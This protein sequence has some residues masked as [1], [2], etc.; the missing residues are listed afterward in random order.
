MGIETY[1]PF[2]VYGIEFVRGLSDRKTAFSA[3]LQ[4]GIYLGT[5]FFPILLRK[6][7]RTPKRAA[8]G[9]VAALAM[10][11]T[12]RGGTEE[13]RKARQHLEWLVNSATIQ[14][15]YIGWGFPYQWKNE[16]ALLEPGTPIGHTTMTCGNALLLY[17]EATREDWVIDPL[18]RTCAFFERGLN[19]TEHSAETASVSYTPADHSQVI[20]VSADV[21]SLLLRAGSRFAKS[22]FAELGAKLVQWVIERQNDDGSWYYYA[23]ESIGK[24]SMI[25]NRHTGMVLSALSESLP[26]SKMESRESSVRALEKGLEYFLE[27]LF[28][29]DALPKFFHDRIYPL[30]IYNFAQAII[31]LL[32]V[33]HVSTLSTYLRDRVNQ[34]LPRLVENLLRLMQKS[35][36][37]FLYMR[38]KFLKTDLHSLR[39]ANALTTYA[40]V[41][42]LNEFATIRRD[43]GV[44][45]VA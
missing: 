22:N 14:N 25:D 40:L 11:Y 31:T 34:I 1:D 19:T 44:A 41:R 20:N 15:D 37:S 27:H 39:W 23:Y 42:Y 32:D 38:E 30:E 18:L 24:E 33:T 10:A 35:D 43:L 28:T 3:V 26:L 13:L 4:K 7:L 9:G 29:E 17:Y 16:G 36:G 2:D 45:A 21:G 8:A 5:R 12:A 6:C